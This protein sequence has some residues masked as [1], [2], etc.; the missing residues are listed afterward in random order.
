[1]L[2]SGFTMFMDEEASMTQ[3]VSG[4]MMILQGAVNLVNA[5]KSAGSAISTLIIGLTKK[6]TAETIKKTAAENSNSGGLIKN[7]AA[8]IA[9]AVAK[10]FNVEASKGLAGAIAGGLAAALVLGT[11]LMV[12]S[13]IATEQDTK[14]KE[15]AA[16]AAEN[17]ANSSR[18]L[19]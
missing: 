17:E 13:A 3:K 9:N 8:T 19:T 10:I 11:M 2:S 14:K 1:M 16:Q 5:A 15:A 4:A 18:D 6:E 12:N 7:T